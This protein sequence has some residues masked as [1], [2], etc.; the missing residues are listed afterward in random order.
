MARDQTGR[1]RRR[2]ALLCLGYGHDGAAVETQPAG[3]DR[4]DAAA[5]AAAPRGLSTCHVPLV[6]GGSAKA[7]SSRG[8]A[9]VALDAGLR[10]PRETH[11]SSRGTGGFEFDPPDIHSHSAGAA[12]R[13][14]STRSNCQAGISFPSAGAALPTRSQDS[15]GPPTS[16]SIGWSPPSREPSRRQ[17]RAY[18]VSVPCLRPGARSMSL[19]RILKR[20]PGEMC[21]PRHTSRE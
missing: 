6:I 10:L 8:G 5:N 14:L 3:H 9:V 17:M 18:L 4:H 15:E 1:G 16:W 19:D 20:E 12:C 11:V 13:P 7:L 21:E 2:A